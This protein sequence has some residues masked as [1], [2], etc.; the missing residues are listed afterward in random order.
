MTT[1]ASMGLRA[2]Q[3]ELLQMLGYSYQ[4]NGR[5]EQAGIIFAA[6]HTLDPDDAFVAKSLACAYVRTGKPE[7]ALLL[8]DH[9]LDCGDASALTHLLRGQA[10]G[11]LG[12]VAEAARAMRFYV[13][14]RAEENYAEGR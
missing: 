4:R 12:R 6:L 9:L 5:S 14:A 10:L 3:R 13:A 1:P 8:L 2:A 7:Q 11:L